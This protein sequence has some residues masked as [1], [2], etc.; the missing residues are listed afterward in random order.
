MTT[1]TIPALDAVLN[2]RFALRRL[3][4]N[5]ALHACDTAISAEQLSEAQ[6][7]HIRPICVALAAAIVANPASILHDS[8]TKAERDADYESLVRKQVFDACG[9]I[10]PIDARS[11]PGHKIL[12]HYMT[13]FYDVRNYKGISVRALITQANMERALLTNVGMHST[14]YKSELRRMLTLTGGLGNV[15]KYRAVTAK[16][17]VKFYAAKRVLD[18]C[19]GWG[20]R[21]LGALAA[22]P[23]TEYVGCEPDV[24]TFNA[25][26]EIAMDRDPATRRRA[27]IHN[28]PAETFLP[29]LPASSFNMVLTSPPYF[30]LELYTAGIQSV[31]RYKTW[32]SW[33]AEWLTPVIGASLTALKPTGTSCW[34]VKNFKSDGK[35]PL[36]DEVERIHK[37]AG[38]T[39]VRKVAMTGSA[40]PGAGRITD[41]VETRESEEITYVYSRTTPPAAAP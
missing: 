22:D 20:G 24:N 12:D 2:T 18:P 28:A 16:A 25:L 13:H 37:A 11:R 39:C 40:R 31:D 1:P 8:Y 27:T 36:A 17:I 6:E 4:N 14:P 33:V 29:T 41:G 35:Y 30:N 32:D 38:W 7:P 5:K 15:T 23:A 34:S 19:I 21:M 9:M 3:L 10:A 26:V